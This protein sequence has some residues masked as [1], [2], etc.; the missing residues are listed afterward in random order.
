VEVVLEAAADLE[1]LVMS[2]MFMDL[3][4]FQWS[5]FVVVGPYLTV[6]GST[7]RITDGSPVRREVEARRFQSPFTVATICLPPTTSIVSS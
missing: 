3:T 7:M 2:S 4:D 5:A 1:L 6:P